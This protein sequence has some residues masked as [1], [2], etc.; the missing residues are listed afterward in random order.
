MKKSCIINFF[1]INLFY[2]YKIWTKKLSWFFSPNIDLLAFK[3][4]AYGKYFPQILQQKTASLARLVATGAVEYYSSSWL[5]FWIS[6][7][8]L[9]FSFLSWSLRERSK[10]WRFAAARSRQFLECRRQSSSDDRHQR[11]AAWNELRN[12][13]RWPSL[14]TETATLQ[15]CRKNYFTDGAACPKA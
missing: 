6:I 13:A 3:V 5:C 12:N 2:P 15:R 9:F 8:S 7:S 10:S 11:S 4:D 1:V 14:A